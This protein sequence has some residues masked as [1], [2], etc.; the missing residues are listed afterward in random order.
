MSDLLVNR[1]AKS[2]LITLNLEDFYPQEEF[3]NFDLKDYLF[4][5]MILK[6]KD[7]R[8]ALKEYDWDQ[9][10]G[11]ILLI[12]NSSDAIV[13]MWSYMLIAS[14]AAGIVKDSFVGTQK[15]YLAHYYAQ[16][17][18]SMSVKEYQEK[19]LVI[20]GCSN[21]PVPEEAYQ[22]LTKKLVP[23]AKSIMFGE[24][25]STVPIYKMKKK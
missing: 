17:I 5:E 11:K 24:P 16:F 2:G 7:F 9:L 1:V 21:K 19:M 10:E 22:A 23:V 25:C 13:P 6:E 8:A 20:K 4:M 15:E 14:Y 18:N 12:T 3:V